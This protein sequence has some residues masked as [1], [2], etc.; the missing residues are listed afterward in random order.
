MIQEGI[1]TA[2]A[3]SFE[4]GKTPEKGTGFVRVLFRI[5]GPTHQGQTV[6]F[7]GWLTDRA[8]DRTLESLVA[9]GFE[10]GTPLRELRGIGRV[11]CSIVVEHES[12]GARTYSRVRWVNTP[13]KLALKPELRLPEDE[14]QMLDS[15]FDEA[16]T[17]VATKVEDDDIPF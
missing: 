7:T 16:L 10:I 11:D 9:A 2:R 12:V 14:L 17:R 8:I 3:A 4:F 13:R 5:S 15:K 1:Y 6:E